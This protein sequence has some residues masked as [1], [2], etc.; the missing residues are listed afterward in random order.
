[1]ANRDFR[2]LSVR[3]GGLFLVLFTFILLPGGINAQETAGTEDGRAQVV[4]PAGGGFTVVRGD[5]PVFYSVRDQQT[6]GMELLP[7]DEIQ[8]ESGTYLELNLMDSGSIIKIA[9][10][11]T[12]RIKAVSRKGGGRFDL[13]YGRVRAKVNRLVQEDDFSISGQ[14]TVAGVRGTDFGYDL[15]YE[16]EGKESAARTR[17]YCFEGSVEVSRPAPDPDTGEEAAEEEEGV[18][19]VEGVEEVEEE[20]TAVRERILISADE[21]VDFKSPRRAADRESGEKPEPL[22][23]EPLNTDVK[24]F[25]LESQPFS[26][27]TLLQAQA[28]GEEETADT[29]KE[30]KISDDAVPTLEDGIRQNKAAAGVLGSLFL[31]GGGAML[32]YGGSL[33]I[34]DQEYL[35]GSLLGLGGTVV[36]GGAVYIFS[37]IF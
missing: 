12:F 21:M 23:K 35:G 22:A 34:N 18:E 6:L 33:M 7:G 14:E 28:A 8:T 17:V 24:T 31:G 11:T 4:Y 1:M 32:Y 25:W 3:I 2:N 9:E 30:Q 5:E 13:A 29:E 37:Q 19:G 10:N 26:E 36:T 27:A 16:Q 15:L 20:E